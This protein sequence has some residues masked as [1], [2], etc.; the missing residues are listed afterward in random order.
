MW[1][2]DKELFQAEVK[3][4]AYRFSWDRMVENIEKL[5]EMAEK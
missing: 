4:E 1:I 5:Y 3:E 2:G